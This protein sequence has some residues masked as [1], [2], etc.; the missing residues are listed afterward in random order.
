G[1]TVKDDADQQQ[2]GAHGAPTGED[3]QIIKMRV[4][5]PPLKLSRT[6]CAEALVEMA[7]PTAPE[8]VVAP[9]MISSRPKRA[10]H[11]EARDGIIAADVFQPFRELVRFEFP[12]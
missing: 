5:C 6:I 10:P 1:D 3:I 11:I 7:G 9:D 4:A 12:S 2:M 8:R